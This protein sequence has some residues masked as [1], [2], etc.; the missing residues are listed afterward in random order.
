MLC[1]KTEGVMRTTAPGE[2]VDLWYWM[3]QRTNPVGYADDQ[4]MSHEPSL[5]DGQK[6]ARLPDAPGGGPFEANWS[7]AA[8]RPR[9]TFKAGG[10]PG[11]V[12]LRKEAVEISQSGRFRPGD[13]LPREILGPPVRPRAGIDARGVWERGRWTV[14]L[15]R[16]LAT[17]DPHDVQFAGP[18]PF[19]FGVSI[20]DDAE[21][22]E[23]AQMGRDV[24]VLRLK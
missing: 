17:G 1:H 21:K 8:N 20:H 14:E 3:A 9:F 10:R 4:V 11:P 5:V 22:D 13:R 2:T 15:R 7:E 19:Y 16:A 23:H 18:G 12:L 6:V 24:L